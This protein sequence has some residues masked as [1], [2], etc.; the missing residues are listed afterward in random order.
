MI[1]EASLKSWTTSNIDLAERESLMF[2]RECLQTGFL[3]LNSIWLL[4]RWLPPLAINSHYQNYK[5]LTKISKI[6]DNFQVVL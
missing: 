4:R 6:L 1:D 3:K 2:L 5:I